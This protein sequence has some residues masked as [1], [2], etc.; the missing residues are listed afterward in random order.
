MNDLLIRDA[1]V[2]N[3]GRTFNADIVVRGGFIERIATEG[4]GA[5]GGVEEVDAKGRFLIPGVMDDQVHFREP[6]LTHKDDIA[7]ASAA[8]AAGGVTS[9]MEM[10]NTNPQTLTQELLAEKYALGA[11]NSVVNYSFYMGISNDNLDEAL[12]TDPRAVC[13]LKAFL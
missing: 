8:A 5:L 3:E 9:Y 7:H 13:G 10:P 2:V 11:A 1:L 6:G 12:R 4:V